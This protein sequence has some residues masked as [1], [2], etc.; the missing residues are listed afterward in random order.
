MLDSVALSKIGIH[1]W[2]EGFGDYFNGFDIFIGNGFSIN[3]CERLNYRRLFEIFKNDAPE[4]LIK[5]FHGLETSNFEYVIDALRTARMVNKFLGADVDQYEPLIEQVKNGLI[6]SIQTT[7]PTYNET[8]FPLMDSL[9]FEFLQ[10]KDIFTTNYDI[11]L[12][13]IV[14]ATKELIENGRMEGITYHDDFYEEISPTELGFGGSYDDELRKIHYLHGSLFFYR[15]H[16]HTY[17]LRKIDNIEYI[18]L[19]K[20]EILNS[21]FP[22]FVAE[23]S[24]KDKQLAINNNSYLSHCSDML[25]RKRGKDDDKLTIYGFSFSSPDVHLIEMINTS[26]IKEMA[27]SLWPNCT[28]D[29]IQAERSRINSLFGIFRLLFMIHDHYSILKVNITTPK[30]NKSLSNPFPFSTFYSFLI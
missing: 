30:E 6:N 29:E 9:A 23:G 13:R 10:F 17:K 12:Y 11:F 2:D 24:S 21:N 25:K 19:I 8:N 15:K 16:I 1:Q 27:V 5:I 7:H 22:V 20:R 18:K 28:I 26:G 14:L 4:T 3:I